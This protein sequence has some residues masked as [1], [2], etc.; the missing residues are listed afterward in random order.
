[1]PLQ[2]VRG[3]NTNATTDAQ[4][5][6][7]AENIA[8]YPLNANDTNVF[9]SPHSESMPLQVEESAMAD[10][11]TDVQPSLSATNTDGDFLDGTQQTPANA[12]G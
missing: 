10:D 11:T 1:M 6:S 12:E 2:G 7:Q 3:P 4:Q 9:L 8:T 5:S